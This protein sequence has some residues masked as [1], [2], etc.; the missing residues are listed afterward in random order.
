MKQD[1]FEFANDVR[2][3]LEERSPRTAWIMIL[4]ILVILACGLAWAKWAV[5]EEVT[6]GQGRVIPSSQLQV[7][8]TLEGGI[9]R[10]ILL[11]EGDLVEQGQV[12]MRIDD[13]GF[14]S[15]LGE[16][17]QRQWSLRAEIARRTAEAN[18]H[19]D[20][21]VDPL[22]IAESP[23]SFQSERAM[24]KARRGKMNDDLTILQEQLSQKRHELDELRARQNK[25]SESLKP[26]K[27]E[28][29]LTQE[30]RKKGVVPEV[31]LLRL[32]RQYAELYGDLE[33]VKA[34][35]P[36]AISVIAEAEARVSNAV[37]T[38]QSEARERLVSAKSELAVIEET[39]KAAQDR[40]VRAALKA[41]VRGVVNKLN[42]TTIGAVVKPGQNLIEIV[43]LDDTLL[44]EA[45]IRP[46][47]VAFIRPNQDASVKLTAYDYS[48]Y[49]ALDG[50]VERISADTITDERGESFYRVIVRTDRNQL[51]VNGNSLPIIPGMVATVD[52]LTGEKTV[53][54]YLMTPVTRVRLEALRER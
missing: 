39:I 43:P 41:P 1:E 26:L 14:A 15:R 18:A 46:Q 53:L 25:L 44:I 32:Q 11:R 28:L 20:M 3:A 49:G 4:A 36:R 5:I 10:E 51:T 37:A 48:I 38:F 12:L 22:L 31:E 35:I 30:L 27:R 50:K 42:V 21:A 6:T 8:Q 16:I 34:S 45:Q 2:T 7:M 9:V 29:E 17:K 52:V 47:D 33:I 24:F 40:V 54:D 13:T 23:E 19:P